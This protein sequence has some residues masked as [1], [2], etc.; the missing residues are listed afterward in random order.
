MAYKYSYTIDSLPDGLVFPRKL[1]SDNGEIMTW[2]GQIFMDELVNIDEELRIKGI[3][4]SYIP[5]LKREI[6]AVNNYKADGISELYN[7]LCKMQIN[8]NFEVKL[9]EHKDR[10]KQIL[11][12][13]HEMFNEQSLMPLT[14]LQ[15]SKYGIKGNLSLLTYANLSIKYTTQ[16]SMGIENF[17]NNLSEHGYDSSQLY[18]SL[19]ITPPAFIRYLQKYDDEAFLSA[20]NFEQRNHDYSKE[21]SLKASSPG[22]RELFMILKDPPVCGQGRAADES[23]TDKA[24]AARAVI[25]HNLF[26]KHHVNMRLRPTTIIQMLVKAADF[27]TYGDFLKSI[28]QYQSSVGYDNTIK[29]LLKNLHDQVIDFIKTRKTRKEMEKFS[30]IFPALAK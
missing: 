28:E 23:S 14:D 16:K 17:K 22:L 18:T 3:H 9:T 5:K 6:I 21:T 8:P 13:F 20:I 25:L 7:E 1:I 11:T 27:A 12:L 29:L 26:E 24:N 10:L 19:D 4:E 15:K 30:A 2:S